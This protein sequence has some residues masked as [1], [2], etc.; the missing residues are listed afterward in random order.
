MSVRNS[1]NVYYRI[2]VL[3]LFD[4]SNT[5]VSPRDLNDRTTLYMH[6]IINSNTVLLNIKAI[7]WMATYWGFV[8]MQTWLKV[9]STLYNITVPDG[10]NA[11]FQF[12]SLHTR[13]LTI[14]FKNNAKFH[15]WYAWSDS[16]MQVIN[17]NAVLYFAVVGWTATSGSTQDLSVQFFW[18]IHKLTYFPLFLMFAYPKN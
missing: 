18:Y 13:V 4:W 9:R 1:S 5:R 11:E 10:S 2:E 17:S 8:Y 14:Y 3:L 7:I 12:E 16:R 6:S 15:D